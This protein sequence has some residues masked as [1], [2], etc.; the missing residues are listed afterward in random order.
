MDSFGIGKETS[1]IVDDLLVYGPDSEELAE[2]YRNLVCVDD[3]YGES[4][5]YGRRRDKYVE[6]GQ[7]EDE[8]D[9]YLKMLPLQR[10]RLF[11]FLPEHEKWDPWK[12]TVYRY[13][14]Q[15]LK[16]RDEVRCGATNRDDLG[17]IVL[18]LNRV[19]TG[20]MIDEQDYLYVASSGG[21]GLGRT[22]KLLI[23]KVPVSDTENLGRCVELR[24]SKSKHSIEL[25]VH[26]KLESDYSSSI[27]IT[28]VLYEYL[29]RISGGSLPAS[30]SHQ[31]YEDVLALKLRILRT[32]DRLRAEGQNLSFRFLTIQR[33]GKLEEHQIEVNG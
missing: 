26:L 31:C 32:F 11:F 8:V 17:R 15:Y 4:E 13:G 23:L 27:R 10:Q 25:Y 2:D 14:G 22:S 6:G 3:Y 29:R 28:P 16:I 1:N 20:M 7:G 9:K 18:G 12:M 19:F 33:S 24:A 5:I 21:D 30:F